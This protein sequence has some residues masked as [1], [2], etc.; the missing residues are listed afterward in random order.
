MY[1]V[2]LLLWAMAAASVGYAVPFSV[3][4]SDSVS[5]DPQVQYLEDGEGQMRLDDVR[6]ANVHWRQNGSSAF[7]QGYSA[8]VWWLHLDLTNPTPESIARYL[9]L[10][11][12]VLD[13]VDVYVVAD[14]KVVNQYRLGDMHPFFQRPVQNQYFVV[15]LE[16]QP[17]QQLNLYIRIRTSTAV[18][19]PMTLWKRSAFEAHENSSNIAQG[20]Y[21]GAMVV[22]AAYNLLIFMMLLERTYLFYFG[23]IM[24]MPMFLAS[25]SGQAY[26]YLWP[27]S[28]VWNDHAIPLFLGATFMFA[29]FFARR[30][31]QVQ[32][33][34]PH[35]Y[36]GL[37]FVAYASGGSVLLSFFSPYYVSIHLLVPLG[38]F[39]CVFDLVVG[40]MALRNHV[41]TA[42][43]Y[44]IAWLAFLVGGTLLALNKLDLI[45]NN[46]ITEYSVQIGSLLEAVLLSFAMAERINIERKLRFEAQDEALKVTR[47][48]NE[49]LELRVKE[50]TEE[51][52]VLNEKLMELSNTDQLTGLRNRRCLERVMA[53]EWSR[54]L[55]YKHSMAVLMM[56][57]DYFKKVN[58]TYGHPAGDACLQQVAKHME[59]GVRWP[60]D[61]VARYGGEEFCMLLPE[62]D[63]AGAH[64]VAERIRNAVAGSP[65]EADQHRFSV[66]VSIGVYVGVPSDRNGAEIMLKRADEALYQAKETGRNRVVQYREDSDDKVHS[67]LPDRKRT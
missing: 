55:R 62:T 57:V 24:S 6:R 12:A 4:D 8:S 58:D 3:P 65:V 2:F 50:R 36:K 22:I 19:V 1:R 48:L 21:Y 32:K 52:E 66:T 43:Y 20:F 5:L 7:N 64:T 13:Y 46:F 60:S 41:P 31:L 16:W 53:E 10:E 59:E 33:W 35:L 28:V 47:R 26:R 17:H 30:F 18:Q 15:P 40:V 44:F 38:L 27:D 37:T 49:E 11:Y 23:F 54:C 39:A 56:D 51:L 34:S 25:L 42:R 29:A 61:R 67:L 14:N 45:P 9:S 63:A